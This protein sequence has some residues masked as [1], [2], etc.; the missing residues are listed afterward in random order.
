MF[1]PIETMLLAATMVLAAN[2]VRT[3]N[4]EPHRANI[5]APQRRNI[6]KLTTINALRLALR[7]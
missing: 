5:F 6:L 7:A 1:Q 4:V 2:G 3:F